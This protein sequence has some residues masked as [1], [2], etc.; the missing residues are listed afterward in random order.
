MSKGFISDWN[1]SRDDGR[2][3]GCEGDI[4]TFR[5]KLENCSSSLKD[6]LAKNPVI[7]D[8]G[9]CPGPEDAKKVTFDKGAG[10]FGSVALNVD[11]ARAEPV[12]A[13]SIEPLAVTS[14]SRNVFLVHGHDEAVTQSVARFLEKLDLQ[15]IILHEQPSMG[16]TV[17]EKLEANAKVGFVV[18]LLTPDDVGGLAPGGKLERRPRQN[19]ILE[20]GYFIGKLGRSRVCALHVEG[21]EILSDFHGVVYVPYDAAGGWRLELASEIRAAGL[22]VDL[23]R[24]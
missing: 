20:L 21:V 2:I 22:P 18:V 6:F 14:N 10:P 24:V 7:D 17:F 1:F 19:V 8:H 13:K 16:R 3:S 23:N 11:L 5:F 4:G 9:P 12:A 15:P